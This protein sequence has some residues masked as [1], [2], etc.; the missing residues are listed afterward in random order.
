MKAEP[1]RK[2]TRLC[3]WKFK[4]IEC[5]YVPECVF[6]TVSRAQAEAL[7]KMSEEM[8][9]ITAPSYGNGGIVPSF[10]IQK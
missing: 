2:V 10:R 8:R 1:I 6:L 7:R 9:R 5:E 3:Q 4:A